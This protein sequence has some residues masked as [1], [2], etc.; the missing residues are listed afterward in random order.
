MAERLA[1]YSSVQKMEAPCSSEMS[2]AFQRTTRRFI[3]EVR[4]LRILYF[5][6]FEVVAQVVVKSYISSG[7]EK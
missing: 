3:P 4:T 2:L 7:K 6:G 5:V 1:A